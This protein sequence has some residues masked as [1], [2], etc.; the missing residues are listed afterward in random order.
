MLSKLC[1]AILLVTTTLCLLSPHTNQPAWKSLNKEEF[2]Q[3]DL[4]IERNDNVSNLCEIKFSNSE[5]V[6]DKNYI[7]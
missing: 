1:V 5:F 6:I 2:A 4:L 7:K 3:I